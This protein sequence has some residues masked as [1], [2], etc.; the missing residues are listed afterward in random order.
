MVN[1]YAICWKNV[2]SDKQINLRVT[3]KL[4]KPQ[5]VGKLP[6]VLKTEL[7]FYFLT[8]ISLVKTMLQVIIS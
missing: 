8:V 2:N 3:T 5:T 1:V 4:A 7:D 6:L